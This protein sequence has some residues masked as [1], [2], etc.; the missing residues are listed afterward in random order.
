VLDLIYEFA[1]EEGPAGMDG[2][3]L[4]FVFDPE[5]G[6]SS[7]VADR[8]HQRVVRLDDSSEFAYASV[9]ASLE[10]QQSEFV[11]SSSSLPSLLHYVSGNLRDAASGVDDCIEFFEEF[12]L[13]NRCSKR[14]FR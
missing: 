6:V 4:V 10:N 13:A 8:L 12:V 9:E 14:K 2:H 11:T 1:P 5:D 3:L 7:L